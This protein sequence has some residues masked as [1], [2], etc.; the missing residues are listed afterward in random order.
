MKKTTKSIIVQK[1]KVKLAPSQ[2][3]NQVAPSTM[4]NAANQLQKNLM[5]QQSAHEVVV[6]VE[7]E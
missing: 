2:N 3:G 6:F 4:R 7:V 1:E 5:R